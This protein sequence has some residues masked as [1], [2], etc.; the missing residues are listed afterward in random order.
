MFRLFMQINYGEYFGKLGF[1]EEFYN[2]ERKE[3][4]KDEIVDEINNIIEFWRL[5][6][7]RL[8]FDTEALKFESKLNFNYSFTRELTNLK[9]E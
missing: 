8:D 3:F 1:A 2:E 7:P 5:K 6:Y 9:F 4:D